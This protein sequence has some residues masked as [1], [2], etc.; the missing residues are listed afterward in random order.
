[1]AAIDFKVTVEGDEQLRAASRRLAEGV[2]D[3]RRAFPGVNAVLQ[4]SV[5]RQFDSQGGQTGGWSPLSVGYAR[6]KAVKF[7]GQPIMRATGALFRSLTEPF[8]S[9]AIFLMRPAE[10]IR[11]SRL[12]YARLAARRRPVF[13]PTESDKA[14]MLVA[15]RETFADFSRT[16]GF[17]VL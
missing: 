6:W 7:P 14:E 5:A 15:A 1:M 4:R 16:L 12:P 3:F 13:A 11:G 17:E 2:S 9:N 8:D 10:M